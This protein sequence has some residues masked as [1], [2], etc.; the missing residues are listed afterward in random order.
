MRWVYVVLASVVLLG[1]PWGSMASHLTSSQ[2]TAIQAYLAGI[3]DL[4]DE[5]AATDDAALAAYLNEAALPPY[6]VWRTNVTEIEIQSATSV[7]STT[8]DWGEYM[9]F[10]RN[11]QATW[12]RIFYYGAA[13]FSKANI[14]TGL[15]NLFEP[16]D[17]N[18]AHLTAIGRRPATRAEQ[19]LATGVGSGSAGDPDVMSFEGT[20]TTTDI[21]HAFGRGPAH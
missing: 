16:E 15:I 19:L 8:W 13:D 17:T 10:Q 11:I 20:I 1:M 6:W 4:A 14:R 5:I 3:G 21:A 2:Y 18:I 9:E 7:D 12:E